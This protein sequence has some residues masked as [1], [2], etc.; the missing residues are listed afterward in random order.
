[1]WVKTLHTVITG[2]VIKFYLY[3]C[4]YRPNVNMCNNVLRLKV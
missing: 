1:M 2:L 4:L 3:V